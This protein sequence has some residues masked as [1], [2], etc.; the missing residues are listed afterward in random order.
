LESLK[1]K[2]VGFY[3]TLPLPWA[4][5]RDVPQDI[6][7]AAKASKT[8][9][10]QRELTRRY[11]R[12][13]GMALVHETALV[14]LR[15]DSGSVKIKGPLQAVAAICR[16]QG[17]VMLITDF[18]E[19]KQWRCNQPMM[20]AVRE[21]GIDAFLIAAEP[22]FVDGTMFDPF[23]HFAQ[24]RQ[25]QLDWTEGKPARLAAARERALALKAEGA[26]NPEIARRLNAESL[27][28]ATGKPWTADSLRKVLAAME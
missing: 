15:P 19:V 2:A 22:I 4:G 21:L 13:N 3:W 5:F 23:D 10:F 11:A 17:A 16:A 7:A 26:K 8:I 9:A 14:E 28:T 27:R 24:W 6:D 12:Q 18:T 20:D 25:R 1:R